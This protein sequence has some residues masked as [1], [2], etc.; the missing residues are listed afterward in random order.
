MVASDHLRYSAFELTISSELELPELLP[1]SAEPDVAIRRASVPHHLDAPLGTGV[2]FEASPQQFLLRVEGVGRYLVRDGN[3]IDVDADHN[4]PPLQLRNLLLGPVLTALLHQRG[5]MVL[6]AAGVVGP[7]G[8][9]LMAGGSGRGKSTLLAA[10]VALGYRVLCDDAAAI[11]LDGQGRPFVSPGMPLAKLWRDAVAKLGYEPD[12]LAPAAHGLEKYG[13]PLAPQIS[14]AAVPL[15]HVFL[16]QLGNHPDVR[17]DALSVLAALAGLR[18]HTRSARALEGLR[19]QHTNF[20]LAA[21]I[22]SAVPVVRLSR[23]RR[24]DSLDEVIRRILPTL[25]LM[26]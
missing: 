17:E 18:A 3:R 19:M 20:R 8:A 14:P 16:L 12:S 23:P 4:A 21:A 7:R 10:L 26:S 22:A 24:G 1:G 6:H 13:L 5:V 15:S 25:Q 11:R 2:L 9:V